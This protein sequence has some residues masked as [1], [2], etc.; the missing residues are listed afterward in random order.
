[1]PRFAANLSMLFTEITFLD[2]FQAA[3]RAGF[4][5]VEFLFPYD[6]PAH[7][8]KAALDDCGLPLV[9][10]NTPA[11][12]WAK[13]ARGHAALPGKSDQF[14]DDLALAL[15]YAGVLHPKH[16]HVMAGVTQDKDALACFQGSLRRATATAPAQ[17]FLIE[18]LN[19]FDMPGYF[20]DDFAQARAIIKSV[21]A[22]NLG[23]QFDA[24]H[25]QR[26]TGDALAAWPENRS[27][28]RHIQIAGTPGRH[29][30][31]PS[32]IDYKRFFRQ[33]EADGY[34]E[35]ISGEYRPRHS[36]ETSLDWMQPS[37]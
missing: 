35:F 12:D 24:Y 33:L 19:P 37:V 5:A 2:R 18:P 20:L 13:G 16:I 10:F 9:L 26:I 27:L 32:D 31:L 8:I 29:D 30:P 14:A 4:Q 7:Q 6:H 17:G 11:G 15:D 23:L 28:S 3:R 34:A 36:T 25:A 22:P 21:A 1:M